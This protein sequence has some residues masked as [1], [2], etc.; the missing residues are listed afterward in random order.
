MNILT[1]EEHARLKKETADFR[2]DHTTALDRVRKQFNIPSNRYFSVRDDGALLIDVRRRREVG[3][4]K[5]SKSD[6]P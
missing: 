2:S 4:P 3:Y 1:L 6:Q 5:I